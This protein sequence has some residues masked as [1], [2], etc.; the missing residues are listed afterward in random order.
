V[1]RVFRTVTPA[2]AL[3]VALG[4]AGPAV[5]APAT[6]APATTAPATTAPAPTAPAPALTSLRMANAVSAQQGHARFLVGVKLATPSKLTVQVL[7]TDGKVV[8]TAT[9]AA[10][11]PAGRAYVRVDATDSSGYQ[12][13][14][15]SYKVR[16]RATDSQNRTSAALEKPFTLK[17]TSPRGLFDAYTVPLWGALRRQMGA[18]VAGQLVAVPGVKGKVLAAGIRRGDIITSIDGRDVSKPGAWAAALRALPADRA[19]AIQFNRKGVAMTANLESAPDWT[20]VPDYATS[21][22]VA[23]KRDPGVMAYA[24]AQA[25]QQI[26]AGKTAAARALI[27][28]WPVSWRNGG[29]GQIVQ[30]ELLAKQK[31][32]SQSLGAYNRARAK[33]R[34]NGMV[35]FGR[36][37]ALS[38]LN[39]TA[40]SEAAFALAGRLD[41]TDPAAA[42]YQSYALL[43]LDRTAEALA[44]SQRAVSLDPR[45]ADAFLPYG[46]SLLASGDRANGVVALRRGLLLLEEP[47]RANRLIVQHLNPTDP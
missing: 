46:I 36:G 30:G 21:L 7:G 33:D 32:W 43:M 5:A 23:V 6:T 12:L 11:R 38:A 2:V 37:V 41:P 29:P 27:R 8:Q 45:Y 18:T 19:V 20:A 40:E 3:A 16:V 34:G 4:V 13:L 42:A 28:S 31:R 1:A 17:L 14:A 26:E 15:G 9:D 47:D 22:K 44:A 25:R 35:A 39:R 24:V 10:D